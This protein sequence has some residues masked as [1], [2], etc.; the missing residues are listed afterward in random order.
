MDTF[1]YIDGFNLY[2]GAVK[3]TPYKWLNVFR[4]C[5]ELLPRHN[6]VRVKYYTANVSAR[7]EDPD[8]PL[9]QQAYLRALATISRLDLVYGQFLQSKVMMP[10]AK[11]VRGH[12]RFVQV[13]KTE[14][15][16]SD[17]NIAAHMIHDGHRNLY[18]AAV[19]VSNDSD[20][21]EP[22]RI[23]RH[24]LH[25][26][27]GMLNPHKRPSYELMKHVMFVKQI[28]K[29]LLSICQFPDTLVDGHGT[30]YKPTRW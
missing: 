22:L 28:R 27:V 15:K 5:Q 18:D 21:A 1:V 3:N 13:I 7:A 20:L 12:S 2:Y 26:T 17:V 24:E 30:F 16:G 29:G 8:Q 6:I 10:L 25:K 23:V 4:M 9:R 11:P 14:E 19:I